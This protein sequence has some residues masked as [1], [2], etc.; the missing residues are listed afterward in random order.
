VKGFQHV[1]ISR[2]FHGVKVL[3]VLERIYPGK[4]DENGSYHFRNEFGQDCHLFHQ[5]Q[6]IAN[7]VG[8]HRIKKNRDLHVATLHKSKRQQIS[9]LRQDARNQDARCAG[10]GLGQGI[11]VSKNNYRCKARRSAAAI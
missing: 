8:V 6:S 1:D 9:G 2:G 11:A 7:R 10:F 4:S 5:P 3:G